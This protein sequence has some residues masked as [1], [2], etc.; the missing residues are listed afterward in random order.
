MTHSRHRFRVT[1]RISRWFETESRSVDVGQESEQSLQRGSRRRWV[2]KNIYR[3]WSLN[4]RRDT[5]N[6]AGTGCSR[7]S[8][9]ETWRNHDVGVLRHHLRL[10]V[11]QKSLHQCFP[12]MICVSILSVMLTGLFFFCT[13]FQHSPRNQP[14][15]R[16]MWPL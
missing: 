9:G 1:L 3:K 12:T 6:G 8:S 15:V 4:G 14:S 13:I 5:G 11:A 10:H 2:F 7:E 16:Y